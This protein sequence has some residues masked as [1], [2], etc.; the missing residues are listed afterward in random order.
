MAI[1]QTLKAQQRGQGHYRQDSRSIIAR[2][3]NFS[4][5]LAQL[6]PTELRR[7]MKKD[8]MLRD[9]IISQRNRYHTL[10]NN[11]WW[12]ASVIKAIHFDPVNAQT[13]Q[14]QSCQQQ[15][16]VKD[17]KVVWME[18]RRSEKMTYGPYDNQEPP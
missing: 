15:A 14:S 16:K 3:D 5:C 12:N 18:V 17:E 4:T 6:E 11:G 10:I 2:L 1:T 8:Q 13:E 7:C 9:S